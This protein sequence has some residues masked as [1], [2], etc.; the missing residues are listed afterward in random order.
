MDKYRITI[1]AEATSSLSINELES[2][3]V[4]SLFDLETEEKASDGD[5][6]EL[7]IFDYEL[8]EAIPIRES[9]H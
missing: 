8:T 7:Q 4:A 1:I 2:R 5:S 9:T 3:L 6:N